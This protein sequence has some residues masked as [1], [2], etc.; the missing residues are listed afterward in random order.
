METGAAPTV[1]VIVG[2]STP[3]ASSS[4]S[5]SSGANIY[6]PAFSLSYSGDETHVTGK[7]TVIL[8]VLPALSSAGP[9]PEPFTSSSASVVEDVSAS[10]PVSISSIIFILV[11]GPLVVSVPLGPAAASPE[12]GA[13]SSPE[14]A[15]RIVEASAMSGASD[16]PSLI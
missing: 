4:P 5:G 16:T 11:C 12:P 9:L 3:P 10:M 8:S 1:T 6:V 15:I 13:G 7:E 14:A 2:A